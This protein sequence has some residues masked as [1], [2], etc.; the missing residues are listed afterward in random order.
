M[1]LR[2]GRKAFI[3]KKVSYRKKEWL[4]QEIGFVHVRTAQQF[5]KRMLMFAFSEASCLALVLIMRTGS[6]AKGVRAIE[7]QD[8]N[9]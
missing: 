2:A 9:S 7:V 6:I 8:R 4:C 3:K 5:E 1:R